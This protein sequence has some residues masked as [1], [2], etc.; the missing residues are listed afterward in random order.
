M[1]QQEKPKDI[2]ISIVDIF[3]LLVQ[4]NKSMKQIC[5]RTSLSFLQVINKPIIFYQLEFLE[6]QGIKKVKLLIDKDDIA[7]KPILDSFKGKI[8]FDIIH[9][10][11]DKL[12]LFEVI[13]ERLDH[14]NFILIEGDS[15][16]S[17]DM[18]KFIENHLNEN[19]LLS[20]VLQKQD[21]EIK[22]LKKWRE[23]TSYLYGIDFEHNNRIVFYKKINL[24]DNR[25]INI[26]KKILKRCPKIGFFTKYFDIGFYI[27]NNSI[28]D[29]L[30]MP[31]IKEKDLELN[32][33]SIKDEFIP[34]LIEKTFLKDF[35]KSLIEKHKN[36]LL[37]ANRIKICAK[38]I[39]NNNE[40][41]N[42]E[43]IYKIYDYLSYISTI[44][45][46]QKPLEKIKKIFLQTKNNNKNYI[47]N[48]AEK[49]LENLDNNK[50]YSDGIP[51]LELISQDCYLAD[52]INSISKGTKIAKTVCAQNLKVDENS[53]IVGCLIGL[54]SE[55]G[56]NCEIKNCIIG[57]NV[58]IADNSKISDCI[59]GD[60][61]NF[62]TES[63]EE[64]SDEIFY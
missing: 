32:L 14:N 42:N 2:D 36:Q 41:I 51:E 61:Y 62:K 17:F 1:E 55:I 38:L 64:V 6:R 29:V 8:K 18:W 9:I 56:K 50:K 27:F 46:I 15:I 5:T 23:K 49:I 4:N 22:H 28:F 33:E 54:D 7:S 21:S 40:N 48:F 37:Q 60:N 53:I 12:N 20:L 52:K 13:R 34:Y 26:K 58:I 59:L 43:Y 63:K 16:L 30:E 39:D 19:N 3:I 24:D 31:K 11:T 35:N 25:N 47:S 44:E 45:E 10:N 57:D